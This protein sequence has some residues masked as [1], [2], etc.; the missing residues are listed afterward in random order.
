MRDLINIDF[1]FS[2]D[3]TAKSRV[4]VLDTGPDR[5]FRAMIKAWKEIPEFQVVVNTFQVPA[6]DCDWLS[7]QHSDV[8]QV[9][10]DPLNEFELIE[11]V[12]KM[13]GYSIITTR[14]N[15]PFKRPLLEVL[16][17]PTQAQPLKILGQAGSTVSH[18]DLTA[19]KEHNVV[20]TYTPGANANAVAEFVMAQL[21]SLVR[22][23]SEYNQLTHDK[24]WS[25]YSLPSRDELNEKTLGLIGFGHIAR[26]VSLK[27]RVLGMSVI[28][29]TR[30]QPKTETMGVE[31]VPDLETL[32]RKANIISLH[33]PFSSSTK[34]LIGKKEITLMQEGSYLINTSRGG[35]VDEEAVAQELKKVNSKLAG[36]AFD[37][38]E[39]EAGDFDSP[40]IGCKKALLTPHIAGTTN[41]ALT[42]TATQLVNNI[43]AIYLNLF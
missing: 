23:L 30:T 10:I 6:A 16:S 18:I 27:A 7:Q 26:A 43:S 8:I 17:S 21:F 42:N 2:A 12:E 13:G 39:N 5:A 1:P 41:A 9:K 4:L 15:V 22:S 3:D 25:K 35:I 28:S 31:F 14:L 37:V 36:V 34:N 24:V 19:A 38:F 11:H 29:Y 20:V 32:L 33:I 40:L